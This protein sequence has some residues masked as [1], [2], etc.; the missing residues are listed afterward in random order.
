MVAISS[1]CPGTVKS[2]KDIHD[3]VFNSYSVG[4]GVAID[5]APGA[6]VTVCA[7]CSGKAVR[8]MPH[9]FVILTEGS[10][11]VLVHCGID[12]VRMRGEGFELLAEQGE[13]VTEGQPM[14][15]YT[16]DDVV[17]KHLD[18]AVLVIAMD[19][20]RGAA[21]FGDLRFGSEVN[22]GDAL[23]TVDTDAVA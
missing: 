7:P 1:P 11:G 3:P 12:T 21:E 13:T 17:A 4:D 9:A 14:V 20:D 2:L 22:V 23:M 10:L 15:R 8:V 6:P 16:P 5:P 18:P 19:T